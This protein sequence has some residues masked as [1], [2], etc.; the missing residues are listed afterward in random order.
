MTRKITTNESSQKVG[1]ARWKIKKIE[2]TTLKVDV[3][4]YLV[5]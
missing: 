3:T 1:K 4:Y 2:L 5:F